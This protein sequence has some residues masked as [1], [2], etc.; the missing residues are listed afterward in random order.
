[1]Y[2][3]KKISRQNSLFLTSSPPARRSRPP[4]FLEQVEESPQPL[5]TQEPDLQDTSNQPQN[6]DY[7]L[8]QIPINPPKPQPAKPLRRGTYGIKI[9]PKKG[10]YDPEIDTSNIPQFQGTIKKLL[11]EQHIPYKNHRLNRIIKK[12]NQEKSNPS[13]FTE[14]KYAL[15]I[16]EDLKQAR[17]KKQAEGNQDRIKV[18]QPGNDQ[19][20][21]SNAPSP[22]QGS[23]QPGAKKLP[24]MER[25]W[26]L[27]GK[28]H[29]SF[30]SL[31]CGWYCEKAAIEYVAEQKGIELPTDF[32]PLEPE[33]WLKI[34]YSPGVEGKNF[35]T[36]GTKYHE[37]EEWEKLLQEVGPVIVSGELGKA[38]W[39]ALG[40]V[41]HFILL[42][43]V[44]KANREFEY[45]DPLKGPALLRGN[46]DRMLP[47]IEEEIY[48]VQTSKLRWGIDKLT[49]K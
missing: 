14:A 28:P 31:N 49:R 18:L 42:T 19:I 17:A 16:I 32:L 39:G 30:L 47:R 7:Q 29:K 43:G 4:S 6:F 22:G 48:Y 34:G 41:G 13:N 26:N 21:S 2:T 27:S 5:Q 33:S 23:Q 12:L 36:K 46:Y 8:S 20:L 44:N 3:N 37:I 9:V 1:M 11:E 24:R 25:Q 40:G 45:L 38:D 35:V 15:Q 10:T